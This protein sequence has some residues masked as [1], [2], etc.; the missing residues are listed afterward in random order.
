MTSRE[1]LLTVLRGGRPDR[2]PVTIY[3]HSPF[4]DDWPNREPSYAPLIELEARFGDSFVRAPIDC[5]VFLGDPNVVRGTIKA[6]E[7]YRDRKQTVLTRC[8]VSEAATAA[9]A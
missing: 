2:V 9:A 6:H 3:E 1:R 5:P 4:S 7:V 8:R